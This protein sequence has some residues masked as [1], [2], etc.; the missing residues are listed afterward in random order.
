MSTCFIFIL[1]IFI[2]YSNIPRVAFA[3]RDL[4]ESPGMRIMASVNLALL[5][6]CSLIFIKSLFPF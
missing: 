5:M 1:E 3:H 2:S 4:K 6:F